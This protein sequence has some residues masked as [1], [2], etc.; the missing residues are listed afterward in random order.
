MVLQRRNKIL[1]D[2]P[3]R[4]CRVP[5]RY[6]LMSVLACAASFYIGTITSFHL[7]NQSYLRLQMDFEV[8]KQEL[9]SLFQKEKLDWKQKC[10]ELTSTSTDVSVSNHSVSYFPPRIAYAKGMASIDREDFLSKYDFGSPEESGSEP[11][12]IYNYASSIPNNSHNLTEFVHSEGLVSLDV[13]VATS[14]CDEMNVVTIPMHY[15]RMC[16][17]LVQNF[18]NYHMQKW[19][20]R[21]ESGGH[22]DPKQPLRYVNRGMTDKGGR[23]HRPPN[24]NVIEKNWEMLK[25]YFQNFHEVFN[26][27]KPI[28]DIV[29]KD[30]TI[31]VLTCN[32]GQSELLMNFVCNSKAKGLDIRNVLVFPTDKETKDLAEGLGL[33]TYH[34]E[35]VNILLL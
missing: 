30:N 3:V 18:E 2:N 20:R 9:E 6:I 10:S 19:M 17:V 11:L 31:I 1:N 13:D 15:G 35:R 25:T 28:L 32:H 4:E 26:E 34:D 22:M 16:T 7:S 23:S 29:A 33:T 21:A 8:Q 5:A 24:Q 12:I 27:L 14:N